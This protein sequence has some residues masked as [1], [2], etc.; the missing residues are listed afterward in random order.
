MP[1]NPEC[2]NERRTEAIAS[3]YDKLEIPN[4]LPIQAACVG[5]ISA[6][7]FLKEIPRIMVPTPQKIGDEELDA[8]LAGIEAVMRTRSYQTENYRSP[9]S[10][11]ALEDICRRE[12]RCDYMGAAAALLLKQL[13]LPSGFKRFFIYHD[14]ARR[15]PQYAD[16]IQRKLAGQFGEK[17]TSAALQRN[18]SLSHLF[19]ESIRL[20]R[21]D[22]ARRV[23]PEER[24][25]GMVNMDTKDRIELRLTEAKELIS[26]KGGLDDV[27]CGLSQYA[28]AVEKKLLP[29]QKAAHEL[30]RIPIVIYS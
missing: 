17:D 13:L 26:Y 14:A 4:K 6:E 22:R 20:Y 2:E 27:Y 18:S 1:E 11:A 15:W 3:A 16:S 24:S 12:W 19:S 23:I 9:E 21:E 28:K 5:L 8:I 10:I 29:Y 7:E 25:K 30:R